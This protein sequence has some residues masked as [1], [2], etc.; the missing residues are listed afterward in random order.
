MKLH[1]YKDYDEYKDIQIK[2][3]IKK[4]EKFMY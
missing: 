1:K 4:Y 2:G 3:N